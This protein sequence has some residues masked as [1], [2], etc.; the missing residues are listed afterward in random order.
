MDPLEQMIE[1]ARDGRINEVETYL[2]YNTINVNGT[3]FG[4]WTALQEACFEG[5][6]P[7]AKL[8]LD[9][10]AD[11]EV[12]TY[13]WDLTPLDLSCIKERTSTVELLLERGANANTWGSLYKACRNDHVGV[14]RLLLNHG[15]NVNACNNKKWSLLHIACYGTSIQCIKEL[16]GRG[17]NVM[18]ENN[19]G[20]TVLD[21]A[22][23]KNNQSIIDL[24]VGHKK[25][26]LKMESQEENVPPPLV[27]VTEQ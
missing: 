6:L 14:L 8:L 5:H 19:H 26:Q 9:H 3:V 1:A 21:L 2:D 20:E 10:G 18:T 12:P 24:I 11:I 7:I 23:N 4:L 25:L 13:G 17:A 15:A 16:L 27:V 22:R